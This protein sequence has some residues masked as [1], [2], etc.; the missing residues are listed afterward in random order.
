[1]YATP[2]PLEQLRKSIREELE[3][4][5]YDKSLAQS[6]IEVELGFELLFLLGLE[7]EPVTVL[8][9]LLSGTPLRHPK[10][11][12]LSPEQRK[13]LAT[14]RVLLPGFAGR[15]RLGERPAPL[16][17]VHPGGEKTLPHRR[18][19]VARV[20]DSEHATSCRKRRFVVGGETLPQRASSKSRGNLSQRS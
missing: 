1:M 20:A 16:R 13:A 15:G 11:Q 18:R 9:V 19:K 14:A 3:E 5:G 6:I 4:H 8:W 12:A 17:A 7:D 10:L 2:E